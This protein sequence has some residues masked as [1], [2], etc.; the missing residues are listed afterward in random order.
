MAGQPT[1]L[2][3]CL[4]CCSS[5]FSSL[6]CSFLFS[7][8]LCLFSPSPLCL[9]FFSILLF[10][11]SVPRHLKVVAVGL[12]KVSTA[13]RNLLCHTPLLLLC[14]RLQS[15]TACVSRCTACLCSVLI[16]LEHLLLA[17]GRS[18]HLPVSFSVFF[19][20]LTLTWNAQAPQAPQ[21]SF[22]AVHSH[23]QT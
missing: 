21:K 18:A 3:P 17:C 4:L 16:H 15:S 22:H 2:K 19:F 11:S 5:P 12:R 7:S 8:L 10:A 6:L 20:S 23:Q 14:L 1:C 9:L 13:V